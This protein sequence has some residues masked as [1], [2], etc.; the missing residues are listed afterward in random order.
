MITSLN[1][2]ILDFLHKIKI[3]LDNEFGHKKSTLYGCGEIMGLSRMLKI[4]T[5]FLKI[6]YVKLVGDNFCHL[7]QLPDEKLPSAQNEHLEKMNIKLPTGQNGPL[8]NKGGSR[9][10]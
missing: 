2:F 7:P 9:S 6:L 4:N 3:L 8:E 5:P 1:F 10:F